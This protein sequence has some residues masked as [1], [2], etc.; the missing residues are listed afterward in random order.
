MSK[1]RRAAAISMGIAACSL[2]TVSPARAGAVFQ[3]NDQSKMEIG[4]WAQG[5]YQVVED[6]APRG[7]NLH[8]FMARRAYLSVKG[9]VSPYFE[10]FTH[11]ATDRLGQDGLDNPSLGLGSGAAFRDLWVTLKLHEALKVQIGRMYVPLTRS[12]GTTSTKA[13]L[14]T[15][16]PFLQGGVRGTTFFTNK[17][18]RDDGI[19]VWGNPLDG[20]IQYRFMVAEGL[21][22]QRNPDDRLRYAGRVAVNLAEPEEAWFNQGTYLGKKKVLSLGVGYD[23]Q[24]NLT[25]N[26]V[27]GEEN[28]VWTVDAF[29][30]RPVGAS[31][32]TI[33]A[34]YIDIENSTQTHNF[35]ALAAGD[36]AANAYVQ[37][38]YLLPGKTGPG[39]FQPYARYETI[40][41][42]AKSST[43]FITVGSNYH[44][45]GHDAKISVDYTVVDP[46]GSAGRQNI[47]TLQVA[48]GF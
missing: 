14:T 48:V 23:T 31:A 46:K 37:A 45:S 38:G 16:L 39:R 44:L 19:A 27:P 1:L 21:E 18:G 10:F 32:I 36:D 17:V 33:E 29:V 11:I 34:A 28:R 15:D 26:G 30:D 22:E 20:L 42:T 4:I 12:F 3:I 24:R 35:S 6:A 43:D 9:E 47:V 8:D 41:V 2:S 5:W 40:D 25:L 13:L 7:G